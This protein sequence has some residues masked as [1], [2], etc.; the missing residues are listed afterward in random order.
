MYKTIQHSHCSGVS[1]CRGQE[2]ERRTSDNRN[3]AV[4]LA[5]SM[6]SSDSACNSQ[7][8]AALMGSSSTNLAADSTC[9]LRLFVLLF[10]NLFVQFIENGTFRQTRFSFREI[11]HCEPL[12]GS[13]AEHS[14]Y[15][16]HVQMPNTANLQH[17]PRIAPNI[18]RNRDYPIWRSRAISGSRN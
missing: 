10:S 5:A 4:Y 15:L 16:I 6:R 8:A 18:A 17:L 2:S 3:M 13:T 7:L 11:L 1:S 12:N 9:C 14:C